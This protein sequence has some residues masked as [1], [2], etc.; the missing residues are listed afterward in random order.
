MT[1][2]TVQPPHAIERV[3][4]EFSFSDPLPKKVVDAASRKF[5]ALSSQLRFEPI[6]HQQVHRFVI[7]PTPDMAPP[8]PVAGWQSQRLKVQGKVPAEAVVLNGENLVYESTEYRNWKTANNRFNSVCG[9]MLEILLNVVDIVSFSHD[10]TDRFVYRGDLKSSNPLELLDPSIAPLLSEDALS[11][12][13]LWHLHRGWFETR[14]GHKYL[15][16]QNLDCQEGRDARNEPARSVQIY[17]KAERRSGLENLLELGLESVASDLH[18]ICNG[19]FA[20]ILCDNGR[21]L[22]KIDEN[23]A[24]NA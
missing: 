19:Y 16:N 7:G 17:T 24:G 22:V 21:K 5:A 15:I 3:R 9:G 10:Y 12:K 1:W 8:E 23:G 20:K 4:F 6:Q 2:T 14:N 11:G 18:S 13:E